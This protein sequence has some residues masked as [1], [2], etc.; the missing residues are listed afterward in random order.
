[1]FDASRLF[2]RDLPAKCPTLLDASANS[3]RISVGRFAYGS[4]IHARQHDAFTTT[5]LK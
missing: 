3:D 5:D 4:R 1:M 2:R